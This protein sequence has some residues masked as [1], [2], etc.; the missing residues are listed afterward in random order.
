MAGN[1]IKS[2]SRKYFNEEIWEI[3]KGIDANAYDTGWINCQAA[4]GLNI[5]AEDE[6]GTA[7]SGRFRGW[8]SN[9]A[10]PP[11]ARADADRLTDIVNRNGI[12][13][14]IGTGG[15]LLA[16]WLRFNTV[17]V[18]VTTGPA[19]LIMKIWRWK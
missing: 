10:T 12:S 18:A 17:S 1:L 13:Y 6:S 3:A 4:I 9:K 19:V 7:W 5:L 8:A 15:N 16:R 14:G 11:D 2:F